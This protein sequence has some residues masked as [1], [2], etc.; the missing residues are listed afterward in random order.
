MRQVIAGVIF[1]QEEK[2]G[3]EY[4]SQFVTLARSQTKS[5]LL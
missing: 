2:V 5:K 1:W 4:S 3:A